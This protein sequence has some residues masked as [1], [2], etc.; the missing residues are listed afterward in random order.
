MLGLPEMRTRW[1][2]T[3][4]ATG[5][6]AVSRLFLARTQTQNALD[7]PAT[8]CVTADHYVLQTALLAGAGNKGGRAIGST[9]ATGSQTV[10]PGWSRQRDMC[11]RKILKLHSALGIS[12]TTVPY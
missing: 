10:D 4:A 5:T 2:I 3:L 11:A 7:V 12:W 1:K 9:D 8:D 6:A